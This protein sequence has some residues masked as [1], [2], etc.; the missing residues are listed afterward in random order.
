MEKKPILNIMVDLETTAKSEN[1]GIL[2]WAMVAFAVNGEEIPDF[3][4][5]RVVTLRS[6]FF[7]GMKIDVDTQEWWDKQSPQAKHHILTGEADSIRTVAKDAYMQLEALAES[8]DIYLWSRGID[9]DLPKIKWCFEHLLEKDEKDFP[10]KF[11]HKMDV[12]T[13]LKFMQIDQSQFEFKGV[14]H[15][16]VDDCMHDIRMIQEAYK[17]KE[18]W[19]M[20]YTAV[21]AGKTAKEQKENN[22]RLENSIE[23]TDLSKI[24]DCAPN[25]KGEYLPEISMATN[26][27]IY[28][29]DGG[30]QV[31]TDSFLRKLERTLA[32]LVAMADVLTDDNDRLKENLTELRHE[33]MSL[34]QQ[35]KD[36]QAKG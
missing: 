1:A 20:A 15:H 36:L 3:T 26:T 7:A 11:S 18:K 8:H 9:F 5:E 13:V 28:A 23:Q 31:C 32:C 22:E 27:V 34:A 16:S 30:T 29:G 35:L 2:S 12:R 10:F 33:N 24:A 4:F 6:C 21:E 14:Q 25:V 17:W 19:M